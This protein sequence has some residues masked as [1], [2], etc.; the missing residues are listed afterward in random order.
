MDSCLRS[1]YFMWEHNGTSTRTFS[2]FCSSPSHIRSNYNKATAA[3]SWEPKNKTQNSYK[4]FCLLT[5]DLTVERAALQS[6]PWKN[7][8]LHILISLTNKIKTFK[9]LFSH[10]YLVF[11]FC[12]EPIPPWPGGLAYR[13]VRLRNKQRRWATLLTQW[14]KK[15]DQWLA[16]IFLIHVLM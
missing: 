11:F 16:G 6:P 9:D 8:K 15:Q 4:V 2:T 12:G 5:S 7:P 14:D 3:T 1:L 10:N 13:A